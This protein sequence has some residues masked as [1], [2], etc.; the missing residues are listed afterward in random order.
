[1]TPPGTPCGRRFPRA[2][3]PAPIWGHVVAKEAGGGL[4]R[5]TLA[6]NMPPGADQQALQ[7][8]Y[9]KVVKRVGAVSG[10]TSRPRR[11]ERLTSPRSLESP[12]SVARRTQ[13][14]A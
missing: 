5:V 1:M 4:R 3:G 13:A 8:E 10:G 2:G 11:T 9:L 6:A 14:N 12:R 7:A